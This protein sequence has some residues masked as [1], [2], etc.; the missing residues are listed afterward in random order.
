MVDPIDPILKTSRTPTRKIYSVS[1][2]NVTTFTAP[3]GTT[4]FTIYF[5]DTEIAQDDDVF[6]WTVEDGTVVFTG[7]APPD[8]ELVI[9][10][11]NL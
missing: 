1:G 11:G 10:V 4:S 9:I 6:S 8:G 7:H 5:G 3:S 2:Q